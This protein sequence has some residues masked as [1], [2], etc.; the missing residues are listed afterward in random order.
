MEAD[1]WKDLDNDE[2]KLIQKYNARVK[3]NENYKTVK[4]PEGVMVI[5]KARRFKEDNKLEHH[6]TPTK[7]ETITKR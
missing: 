1:V 4:F 3:L 5:H 6:E 2:R 7:K